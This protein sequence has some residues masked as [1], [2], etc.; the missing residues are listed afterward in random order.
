VNADGKPQPR[1]IDN[2][3]AV[4]PTDSNGSTNY[5]PTPFHQMLGGRVIAYDAVGGQRFDT[6]TASLSGLLSGN[7]TAKY[8]LTEL[9]AGDALYWG[10]QPG[11]VQENL[12]N[13]IA[14]FRAFRDQCEAGNTQLIY[15]FCCGFGAYFDSWTTGNIRAIWLG[16]VDWISANAEAERCFAMDMRFTL[17]RPTNIEFLSDGTDGGPNYSHDGLHWNQEGQD[18]AARAFQDFISGIES[19]RLGYGYYLPSPR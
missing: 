4:S 17:G 2:I 15:S 5:A 18:A 6:A 13:M 1:V 10:Q 19:G 11:T 16:W 7:P 12:D 14:A 8:V 3:I 9:W